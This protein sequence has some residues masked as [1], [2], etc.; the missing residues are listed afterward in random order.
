M[1]INFKP[2]ISEEN[3]LKLI[4]KEDLK[5]LSIGISTA[6]AAEIQMAIEN[7]I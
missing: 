6:G 3:G 7:E 4:R 2:S 5:I 1:E